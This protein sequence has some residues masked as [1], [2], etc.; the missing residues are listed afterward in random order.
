MLGACPK[1]S[2]C[3]M[4][5]LMALALNSETT[6]V[7]GLN[8]VRCLAVSLEVGKHSEGNESKR[9]AISS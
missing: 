9:W 3:N 7:D 6:I 5:Y 8:G 2:T 4:S 1:Y